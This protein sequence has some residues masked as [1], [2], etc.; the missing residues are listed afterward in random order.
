[1]NKQPKL[2]LS[3]MHKFSEPQLGPG[4]KLIKKDK[5]GDT[6]DEEKEWLNALEEGTLDDNGE[7]KKMKDPALMTARQ[8]RPRPHDCQTGNIRSSCQFEFT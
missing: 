1:M 6:D 2:S 5:E 4:G 8:V 7:L 3:F